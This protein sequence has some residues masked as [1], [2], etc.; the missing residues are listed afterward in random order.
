MASSIHDT[1]RNNRASP[2]RCIF[3]APMQDLARIFLVAVG[4][5]AAWCSHAQSP[6]VAFDLEHGLTAQKDSTAKIVVGI[7]VQN[8]MS[9]T[10]PDGTGPTEEVLD[11]RI[12]RLRLKLKGFAFTP[13]LEY[14]VQLGFS[15][16][17]MD[18]GDG[19]SGPFPIMD[20]VALYRVAPRVQLG[21][22]QMRMPGGRQIFNSDANWET[23]ERPLSATAFSLDRDI[24][25]HFLQGLPMGGQLLNIRAAIT[26]GEGRSSD[27]LNTGPCYTARADWLPFGAFKE[28]SEYSEGDLLREETPKL[29]LGLAYSTDRKARRSRAQLGSYLPDGVR[30]TINTFFA[31]AQFKYHGW[32]WQNEFSRLTDGSPLIADTT[33]Q[34]LVAVNDGWGFASQLGRMLGK[35]SQVVAMYGVV[36]YDGKV[37]PYHRGRDEAL[38]GYNYYIHGHQVKL[39]GAISCAWPVED[40]GGKR[41]PGQWGAMIQLQWGIG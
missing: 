17:D 8:Q 41:T 39:Q 1:S 22:G 12:R 30:R 40:G 20:A 5:L 27:G 2:H 3:A 14:R 25:V 29:A 33:G 13:R 15:K 37:A 11:A 6:P 32:G 18:L 23:P 38:L 10:H 16:Q 4:T 26:Q 36:R 31:D 21:I 34:V 7:R 35:R 28:N 24:G 9:F 19:V